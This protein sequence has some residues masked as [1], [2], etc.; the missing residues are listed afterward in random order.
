MCL[1]LS[2]CSTAPKY[3]DDSSERTHWLTEKDLNVWL[4]I[5]DKEGYWSNG[6]WIINVEGK[7]SSTGNIYRVTTDTVPIGRAYWWYWWYGQTPDDF[8]KHEVRLNSEGFTKII[9]NDF[10]AY[11]GNNKKNGVWHKVK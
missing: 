3:M 7:A 5:K 11:D 6:R 4:S 10:K 8:K 1:F 9:D 2:A